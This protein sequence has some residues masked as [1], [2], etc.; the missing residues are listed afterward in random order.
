[1][2]QVGKFT[3]PDASPAYFIDFLDFLDKREDIRKIRAA[4]AK[5]LNL[6]AGQ[7]VLDLGCGI[8]GATF[9]VAE[10]TGPAGLAAG[11]D[12]SSAM[13]EAAKSRS[14]GRPGVEF[15]VGEA[16]AIPY[17]DGFFDAGRCER[18]FLYVPDRLAA[19]QE[20][21][22]VLKP[23]GRVA[24]LDVDVD[25]TGIYSNKRELT[26]KMTSVVAATVP[27][28][29]SARDLPALARKA[30]L[31]DLRVELFGIQTPYEFFLK[32]MASSLK[33]AIEQG[34]ASASEVEEF[35][36]EQASL[37]AAG[38]FFQAWSYVLVSGIV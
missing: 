9:P 8:G 31:K 35:L 4:A 17:P 33:N 12:I 5:H 32:V 27:N 38:D 14:A 13:V 1:M 20:M 22:R 7:K 29:N 15:R 23:G 6:S 18:V 11:V 10:I 34:T 36:E 37:E 30:G 24:L 16:C 19:I 26:R 3:Q 21:R 25:A 2:T 28:P